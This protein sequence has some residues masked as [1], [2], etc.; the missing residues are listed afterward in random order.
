M[1]ANFWQ[2][3]H[4]EQWIFDKTELMRSRSEDYK[5]FTEE[6]YA[7]FHIFWANFMTS[8]ATEGVHVPA[9]NSRI[10]QQVI[11]TAVTYFKRF[12][13]RRSFK[14]M[15]PFLVSCTS[16][17][18]ACKVE[19]H[20]PLSVSSFLKNTAQILPKKWGVPFDS[21]LSK[22]GNVYDAEFV[23]VE[24]LDCCLIVYHPNRP[25]NQFLTDINKNVQLREF[26]QIEAQCH[27]VVNDTLRCDVGLLFPPHIIAIASLVVGTELMGRGDEIQQWLSEL[28]VDI[29]KV[30]DCVDQ[31]YKMYKLWRDF[32]EKEQVKVLLAKLPKINMM[33]NY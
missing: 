24:I 23:L 29:D 5:L 14:D 7:K 18:L 3:S 8:V 1:A 33:P 26:D 20:T 2:S 21:S 25:L 13:C 32:D 10:R 31:I 30:V 15:N 17:F 9:N 27:K 11:A 12:Y 28:S 22:N 6:E 19:E 4:A 16:L